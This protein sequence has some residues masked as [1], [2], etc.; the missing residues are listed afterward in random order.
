MRVLAVTCHNHFGPNDVDCAQDAINDRPR[1]LIE[2]LESLDH[3]FAWLLAALARHMTIPET[4]H[5]VLA[6]LSTCLAMS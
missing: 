1:S 2:S 3:F 5:S 4:W 6:A